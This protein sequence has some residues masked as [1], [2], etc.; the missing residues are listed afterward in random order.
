MSASPP[1]CNRKKEVTS[2]TLVPSS[3]QQ[4]SAVLCRATS[5]CVKSRGAMLT[6]EMLNRR[7]SAE[8]G[9]TETSS[10]GRRPDD[11]PEFNF[12]VDTQGHSN[13][14]LFTRGGSTNF[15][16]A[17][18]VPFASCY[19]SVRPGGANYLLL[20]AHRGPRFAPRPRLAGHAPRMS[21]RQIC[22]LLKLMKQV[23]NREAAAHNPPA[24]NSRKQGS[25]APPP[26]PPAAKPEKKCVPS[27]LRHKRSIKRAG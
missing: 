22:R 3:T 21:L 24:A 26:A 14:Q 9:S 25:A 16:M 18:V 12:S 23:R 2:Y 5:L 7:L 27:C 19:A 13:S 4:E 1:G 17:T 20:L 8:A 6:V 11:W 10:E 15:S